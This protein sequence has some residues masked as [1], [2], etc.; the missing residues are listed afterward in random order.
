MEIITEKLSHSPNWGGGSGEPTE[1]F[2]RDFIRGVV[3]EAMQEWCDGVE[4]RMWGLQY[5]LL[6]AGAEYFLVASDLLTSPGVR[7]SLG[8]TEVVK[9]LTGTSLAGCQYWRPLYQDQ[10]CP[11]LPASHVTN[12]AGTGL[13][14]TAPAHGQDDF[15]VGIQYGLS[16]DCVVGEDGR[17]LPEAGLGLQ[18]L[19]VMGEGGA[20][21]VELLGSDVLF[22]ETIT[23]SYPYDWRTKKPVLLRASKQWF[24]NTDNLKV[25]PSLSCQLCQFTLCCYQAQ[26]MSV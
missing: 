7:A 25:I 11:L 22:S 23:H 14:H 3:S 18:G 4:Q 13:V 6:R 10:Q 5:S 16:G 8:E 17:Y 12:T 2:Q 24:I 15:R 26:A 9:T 20:K 1:V 21:V 19:E